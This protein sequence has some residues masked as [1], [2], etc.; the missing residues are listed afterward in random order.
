MLN[1]IN[2]LKETRPRVNDYISTLNFHSSVYALVYA[3]VETLT[4]MHK[5]A[6]IQT[7][8]A[9]NFPQYRSAESRVVYCSKPSC[10][11]CRL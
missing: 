4:P 9:S 11:E 7:Y 2:R 3:L 10:R 6:Q 1:K 5:G 8:V